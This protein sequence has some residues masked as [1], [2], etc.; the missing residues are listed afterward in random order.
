MRTTISWTLL[1]LCGASM[2]AFGQLPC[3]DCSVNQFGDPTCVGDA[4]CKC[5]CQIIDFQGELHC[6]A[7]DVCSLGCI[8]SP[9]SQP[10]ASKDAIVTS[11]PWV[12][13]TSVAD[14]I[15]PH[16]RAM[17]KVLKAAQ[18]FVREKHWTDGTG[19]EST[20]VNKADPSGW[21]RYDLISKTNGQDEIRLTYL[22]SLVQE[23]LILAPKSKKWILYRIQP[24]PDGLIHHDQIAIGDF[25]TK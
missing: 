17:A 6:F 25:A 22:K 5:T 19:T 4:V 8:E 18:Y 15:M 16:S 21:V 11:H 13:D 1:F 7:F 23:Q 20:A 12:T 2:L 10:S 9:Q 24:G 3:S 14:A